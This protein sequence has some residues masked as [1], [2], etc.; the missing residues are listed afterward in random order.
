MA[1]LTELNLRRNRIQYVQGLEKLP[2]LQRVFLSHNSVQSLK[3]VWCL[4]EIQYLIELSLDGNPVAEADPVKYR[5]HI[6]RSIPTL[7]HLDLKRITDEDRNVIV[8]YGAGSDKASSSSSAAASVDDNNNNN[9]SNNP[10]QVSSQP[11]PSDY[12]TN[13]NNNTN[14]PTSQDAQQ[15]SQGTFR[16]LISDLPPTGGSKTPRLSANNLEAHEPM[17]RP[18]KSFSLDAN[19]EFYLPATSGKAVTTTSDD[20]DNGDGNRSDDGN[21]DNFYSEKQ[22]SSN[23]N[24]NS[25]SNQSNYNHGDRGSDGIA[26]LARAGRLSRAQAIFDIEV[27]TSILVLL[28]K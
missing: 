13:A 23:N 25:N 11:T 3:D 8:G 22:S 27:T 2:A 28:F 19:G 5:E 4:F 9:N 18:K 17:L 7:K 12:A 14:N 15:Q 20:V 1:S 10:L 26:L 21:Q 16:N 6:I 24:S